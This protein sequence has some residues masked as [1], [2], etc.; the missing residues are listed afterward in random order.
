MPN[1]RRIH[2]QMGDDE[3][4]VALSDFEYRVFVTYIWTADDFGVMRAITETLQHGNAA[5]RARAVSDVK[6][7]LH[8][9]IDVGLL[10]IFARERGQFVWSCKW[11]DWQMIAWPRQTTLP[12][13]PD[14]TGASPNTLRLFDRHPQRSMSDPI[15]G[16]S[17]SHSHSHPD[18]ASQGGVGGN[19]PTRRE[20]Q[21]LPRPDDLQQAHALPRAG[22]VGNP[23]HNPGNLINGAEER[24]HAQH[25]WC[26][27]ARACFCVPY[28][29]H[30][31]L[32]GKHGGIPGSDAA[33]KA[34]YPTVP[35]KFDG[36]AV[37]GRIEDIWRREFDDWQGLTPAVMKGRRPTGTTP[38]D[39]GKYAGITEED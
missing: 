33:L 38:V 2:P 8:R 32:V 7:G 28:W 27:R 20:A 9:L 30:E 29:L 21:P 26:Y 15:L 35:P 18:P 6:A 19:P 3:R 1:W 10:P 37:G 12:M 5:L 25:A 4:V 23:H 14:L 36:R 13:P 39:S 11:Q 31:E 24:R 16:S 34:W 22:S 17:N